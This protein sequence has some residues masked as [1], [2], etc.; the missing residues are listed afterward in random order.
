MKL[1]AG[2][3]L[4][5][6]V[7]FDMNAAATTKPVPNPTATDDIVTH[8]KMPSGDSVTGTVSKCNT[9]SSLDVTSGKPQSLSCWKL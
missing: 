9:A 1:P 5:T 8:P 4:V 7:P 6:M 2:I 3:Q